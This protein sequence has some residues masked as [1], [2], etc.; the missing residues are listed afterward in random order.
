MQ[1]S[2]LF[3]HIPKAGGLSIASMFF[4]ESGRPHRSW[5]GRSRSKLPFRQDPKK[6]QPPI[7]AS[8]RWAQRRIDPEVFARLHKFAVVRD[9][10]ERTISLYEYIRKSSRHRRHDWIQDKNFEEFVRYLENRSSR[11]S[12]T[13]SS[14]LTDDNGEILA[15][16]IIH[17]ENFAV[18]VETL[19]LDLGLRPPTSLPHR[20]PTKRS[21]DDY[22]RS[23]ETQLRIRR[24]FAEDFE[25]FGYDAQRLK[26]NYN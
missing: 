19:C 6:I 9:P 23:K 21:R 20:N 24:L 14:M 25:I 1:R 5:I 8:L 13:Q 3:V 7:H 10:F 18:E 26:N 22:Y 17:F 4:A 12:I 15:D 11:R 2:F 16:R